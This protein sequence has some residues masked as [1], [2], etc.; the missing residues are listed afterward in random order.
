MAS[1]SQHF[2]PLNPN[3]STCL[4]SLPLPDEEFPLPEGLMTDLDFDQVLD[5][6]IEDI[7]SF[8]SE[9]VD[10][11]FDSVGFHDDSNSKDGSGILSLYDDSADRRSGDAMAMMNCPDRCCSDVASV[12]K[13]SA[14][15]CFGSPDRCSSGSA[16]G[17]P[18]SDVVGGVLNL[19]SSSDSPDREV[20]GSASGDR[21]S[22]VV[23]VL[24]P[25]DREVSG[26]V[27]GGDGSSDAVR[28]LNPPSPDSVTRDQG[29]AGADVF[30]VLNSPSPDC[31]SSDREFSGSSS[32][33]SSNNSSA[34]AAVEQKMKVEDGSKGQLSK[35]K[36]GNEDGNIES[37]TSKF[38]RSISSANANS[39][40]AFHAGNDEDEK[41]H[42][43]LMRNR[44]SAQL[45]RQR[46]KHYVEELED[47]VRSMHSTIAELNSKISF[48]MA[49]NA[50]LRQQLGGGGVCPPPPGM[51]PAPGM[52]PMHFPWVP[53]SSY[54]LKPQGSQVPLVPIP[55]LKPQQPVSASRTKKSDSKKAESKTK[56]VASV[57]FMGLLFFL[58]IFGGLVPF[59][60]I[61]F[62]GIRTPASG[63]LN[64]VKGGFDGGKPR[65]RVLAVS[66][67]LNASDQES[68]FGL[69]AG[70]A[71]YKRNN[72]EGIIREPEGL[73][74]RRGARSPPG[75]DGFGFSRNA[76]EP[77]V[78]SLYV[79]RNDKLVKIDGN[80][81]IHSV[82]AS[83][84]AVAFSQASSGRKS[85]KATVS[86]D[87]KV[88]KNG[89]AIAANLA[90][91][92][93]VSKSGRDL[94]RHS[95]MYRSP[96]KQPKA[97]MSGTGD[98]YG[99]NV[100]STTS[101]GPLQQWFREGLA[102]PVLNSGM[103][104]EVFQFEISPTSAANPGAIIP[105]SSVVN[106]SSGHTPRSSH[107]SKVKN[108]R[109][110][111]HRLIPLAGSAPNS[112]EE[113]TAESP[114]D[115][116]FHGNK[117]IS[118]S[119]VVSVLIDPREAG[120]GDGDQM[121]MAPKSLSRIFVVVLLDSVKYVTYSC[122]LPLKGSG[123][124]IVAA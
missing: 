123:P 33:D 41:K 64:F 19:S 59:V 73:Q 53:C 118:S 92:L 14:Q 114:K 47:K 9:D 84:K 36:K 26:S 102:G 45:S 70:K 18:S 43:R 1:E 115:N 24:N 52:A 57:S 51:Y 104:T 4:D 69:Y 94:E 29:F 97:L 82:L 90:S 17:S 100:K 54:A 122:V 30:M 3:F 109:I 77:L 78:A 72:P 13:S 112:T 74:N 58:L 67:H 98:T 2:D 75:A 23:M 71:S 86:S 15:E 12:L 91:A 108:R 99:D 68:R 95:H 22:D 110:L 83:E 113:H 89:L 38:R 16:S 119:M 56:K 120:D 121:G 111:Y 60:D 55:R 106:A 7:L 44:E 34:T 116:G 88:G 105:A 81:I 93:A 66:G 11:P 20:S 8:P 124:H 27:S 65:G 107:S 117:S 96:T 40:G 46:K 85:A 28:V 76:S 10:L 6:S 48:I 61:K 25:P 80:L 31:N 63:R 50:S 42:A 35:R 101:D 5:F 79:P 21:G 49:E 87:K 37:R 62:A 32:L 39:P 103:C